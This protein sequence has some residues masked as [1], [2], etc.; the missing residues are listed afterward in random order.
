[1]CSVP[2]LVFMYAYVVKR[3]ALWFVKSW[4]PCWSSMASVIKHVEF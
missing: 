3:K 1:M 4:Q 2:V